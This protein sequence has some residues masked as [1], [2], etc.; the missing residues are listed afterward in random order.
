[1]PEKSQNW[2]ALGGPDAEI[3]VFN[4]DEAS[5]TRSC[6]KDATV[7]KAKKDFTDKLPL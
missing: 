6:F 5:G 1:M 7:K 3:V 4:R 2:S